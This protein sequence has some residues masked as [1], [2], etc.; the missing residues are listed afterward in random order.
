MARLKAYDLIA[1][2]AG[3]AVGMAL[4]AVAEASGMKAEDLNALVARVADNPEAVEKRDELCMEFDR[5]LSDASYTGDHVHEWFERTYGPI[6]RN[7]IYRARGA[8][9]AATSEVTQIAAEAKAYSDLA[10]AEG[11]DA[12]YG[13]VRLRYNQLVFQLLME[14]RSG[15]LNTDKPEVVA[16]ILNSLAKVQ[17]SGAE[18]EMIRHKLGEM[19]NEFDSQVKRATSAGDGKLSA[20]DIAAI[21]SAVFGEAA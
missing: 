12:M 3:R 5:R 7:S 21:R 18:T 20:E 10:A 4:P 8:V 15:D 13:A 19:R 16:R 11:G 14:L 1:V 2:H 9:R 6:G 17:K